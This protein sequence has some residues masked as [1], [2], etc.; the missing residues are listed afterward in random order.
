MGIC[1]SDKKGR[2]ENNKSNIGNVVTENKT[3]ISQQKSLN[4]QANKELNFI[5]AIKSIKTYEYSFNLQKDKVE[6][7][8]EEDLEKPIEFFI[9]V[10]NFKVKNMAQIELGKYYFI[11]VFFLAANNDYGESSDEIDEKKELFKMTKTLTNFNLSSR[12]QNSQEFR[13]KKIHSNIIDSEGLD[14]KID[15][16][17][18]VRKLFINLTDPYIKIVG[19]LRLL[20]N[21]S[22]IYVITL[23]IS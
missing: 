6:I 20:F 14:L 12:K 2:K 15:R 11:E 1:C 17:S 22:L 9:R 4:S 21:T 23:L 7:I 13:S 16:V 3:S 5:N 10:F 19:L 18:L 8:A